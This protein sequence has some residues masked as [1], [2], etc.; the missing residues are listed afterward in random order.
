MQR[1]CL[2]MA[3]SSSQRRSSSKT[4]DRFLRKGFEDGLGALQS[5][6]NNL[7]LSIFLNESQ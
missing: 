4:A 5:S 6:K 3:C 7:E 2:L 1:G